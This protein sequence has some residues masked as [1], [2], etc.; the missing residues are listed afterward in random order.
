MNAITSDKSRIETFDSY[1]RNQMLPETREAF[2]TSL[3][4]DGKLRRQLEQ[5]RIL[6]NALRKVNDAEFRTRF[7]QV[8]ADLD[9]K[10]NMGS[11][12]SV[13]LRAVVTLGL[14]FFLFASLVAVVM[15]T[16]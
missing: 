1:L 6:M 15:L 16:S 12:M 8:A 11:M 14:G 13:T 4:H 9:N 2:E 3:L 10:E 7:K 5:Y